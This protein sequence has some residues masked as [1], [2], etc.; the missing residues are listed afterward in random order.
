MKKKTQK[1]TAYCVLG[2]V[3]CAVIMILVAAIAG[4]QTYAEDLLLY[5]AETSEFLNPELDYLTVVNDVHPYDFNGYQACVLSGSLIKAPD[6]YGEATPIEQATYIAFTEL[7]AALAEKGIMIELS[8]AW[9]SEADQEWVCE[10]YGN[11]EGWS[12]TNKIMD[13]GYSEHHTGLVV[14]FLVWYQFPGEEEP[15]WGT[16]T[17]E[18]RAA[19]PEFQI[20][21]DTLADY[22]FIER[23]PAG[24]EYFT[25]V[26]CEPYE[27]RFVGS[28]YI[29]HEIMDHGYAL[30]EY[31]GFDECLD[32]AKSPK[33]YLYDYSEEDY[34]EDSPEDYPDIENYQY[35]AN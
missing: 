3:A 12:D 21:Y 27:I 29:A 2:I 11:L 5:P 30:E 25:G 19:M 1:K 8:S 24:K 16:I 23:Y 20:I 7:Q 14:N 34:P 28:S 33:D 4:N 13:P 15:V 17:A 22:G 26:P 31:L 6:A 35:S 10:N 18:R 9:R 32:P